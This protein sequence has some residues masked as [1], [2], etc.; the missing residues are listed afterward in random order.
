[1]IL[2]RAFRSFFVVDIFVLKIPLLSR[3]GFRTCLILY[4]QNPLFLARFSI[5]QGHKPPKAAPYPRG[6]YR[7]EALPLRGTS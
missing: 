5:E 1:M 4:R 3:A 6:P 2:E 7:A